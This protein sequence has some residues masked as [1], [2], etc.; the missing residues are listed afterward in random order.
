MLQEKREAVE[1]AAGKVV[2]DWPCGF[3]WRRKQVRPGRKPV[4]GPQEVS[5]FDRHGQPGRL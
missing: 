5:R 3:G 2:H 1:S 4:G